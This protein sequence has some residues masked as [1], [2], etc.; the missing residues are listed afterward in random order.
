M[1]NEMG[2]A[3]KRKIPL[4]KM[5]NM[6]MEYYQKREKYHLA[7]ELVLRER[8]KKVERKLFFDIVKKS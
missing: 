2:L 7:Y 1:L 3:M 5:K 8:T 4:P 6:Y